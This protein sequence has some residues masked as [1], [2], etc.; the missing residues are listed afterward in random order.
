MKSV[1][2]QAQQNIVQV[3]NTCIYSGIQMM[4]TGA[5]GPIQRNT[6]LW[7]PLFV[8]QPDVTATVFSEESVGIAFAIF[9]IQVNPFED[10][11]Q[12]Q[13][14]ITAQNVNPDN[15]VEYTYWCSYVVIGQPQEGPQPVRK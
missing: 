12:T 1:K 7:L 5:G 4:K 14:A 11:S 2:L 8:G 10:I 6:E 3:G 15:V 13:I 9:Q